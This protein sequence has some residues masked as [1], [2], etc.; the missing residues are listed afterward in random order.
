MV[1]QQC[2]DL[3]FIPKTER[4]RYNIYNINICNLFKKTN[5]PL[6]SDT[7]MIDKELDD[8]DDDG[9]FE[10]VTVTKYRMHEI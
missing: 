2:I 5:K 9:I 3:K 8:T 1:T 6:T 4:L 10:D 7:N